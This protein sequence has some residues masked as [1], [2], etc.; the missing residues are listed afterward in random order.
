MTH[1]DW[2]PEINPAGVDLAASSGVSD[3]ELIEHLA[4][5]IADAAMPVCIVSARR[6][7]ALNIHVDRVLKANSESAVAVTADRFKDLPQWIRS[8]SGPVMIISYLS[9]W[10]RAAS[11]AAIAALGETA[12]VG[13][14]FVF[15]EPTLGVGL[16]SM[17]QRVAR[18][19][20]T[21]R[22][23]LSFHRDIP[24]FLR[25]AGWQLT[26]VKRVVSW[27]ACLCHDLRC[28]RGPEVRAGGSAQAVGTTAP[29]VGG[30]LVLECLC[31]VF[32]PP[33]L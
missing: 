7:Q 10:R 5:V 1:S 16:A 2:T 33:A 13:T 26:T 6:V 30:H 9:L 31:R 14:R 17:I 24:A 22:L 23:G 29:S 3:H 4:E 18:P 8:H 15:V 32:R 20:F 27:S 28:R 21:R 19:L 25:A 12:P 11:G